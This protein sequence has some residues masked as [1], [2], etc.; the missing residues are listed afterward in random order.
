MNRT[1]LVFSTFLFLFNNCQKKTNLP[2]GTDATYSINPNGVP[3][4]SLY[5]VWL[6][7]AIMP[8]NSITTPE[9][10]SNTAM[11]QEGLYRQGFWFGKLYSY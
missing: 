1:M 11:E 8:Q 9:T 10:W 3:K 4:D 5:Q 2:Q 7:T 6:N